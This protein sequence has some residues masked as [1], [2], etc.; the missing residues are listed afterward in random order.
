MKFSRALLD[1]GIM[2]SAIAFPTVP[3]GKTRIRAMMNSDYTRTQLEQT[4]ETFERVAK[5]MGILQ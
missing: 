5:R 4:L 3:E 2:A 1:Q